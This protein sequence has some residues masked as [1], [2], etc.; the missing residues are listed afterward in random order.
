MV[1]PEGWFYVAIFSTYLIFYVYQNRHGL[2]NATIFTILAACIL[3]ALFILAWLYYNYVTYGNLFQLIQFARENY[4][5]EAREVDSLLVRLVKYP[6]MM[7][8]VSPFLFVALLPGFIYIFRHRTPKIDSYL[9]FFLGGTVLLIIASMLGLGTNSTPQRYVVAS[10]ILSTPLIAACLYAI[11]SRARAVLIAGLFLFLL[12]NLTL[13]LSGFSDEYADAAQVGRHLKSQWSTGV[14]TP[15]DGIASE[16]TFRAYLNE[17]PTDYLQEVFLIVDHWAFQIMSNHPE[18][19]A[20][21]RW[22]PRPLVGS[23]EYPSL[24]AYLEQERVKVIILETREP[25]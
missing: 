20:E 5:Q 8:I 23:T 10:V 3:P 4:Q 19:F 13:S 12:F 2:D 14:L 24:Q 21:T 1:R 15:G 11:T 25:N 18:A 22:E 16:K 6:A 9:L 7:F 17:E